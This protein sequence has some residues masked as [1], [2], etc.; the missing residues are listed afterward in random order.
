MIDYDKP[1]KIFIG[2]HNVASQIQ[3]WQRGFE[4]LGHK[5]TS[6]SYDYG[7]GRVSF[8]ADIN[9]TK[10]YTWDFGGVRPQSFRKYLTK[11][12]FGYRTRLLNK[13][14]K[15]HDIFVFIWSSFQN[16]FSDLERIKAAGKKVVVA[17]VGSDVRWYHAMVQDF[18]KYDMMPQE[19]GPEFIFNIGEL[20]ERLRRMRMV[21]RYADL[22]FSLPNQSQLAL[23]PYNHFQVIV[24]YEAIPYRPEQRER[25]LVIHAPSKSKVKGTHYIKPV[26]EKLKE[27]LGYDVQYVQGL[28]YK[29]ALA[30][31]AEAD[32]LVG[33]AFCPTGGKQEREAMSAGTVV[34]SSMQYH[35]PDGMPPN[36]PVIDIDPRNLEEKLRKAVLDYDDRKERAKLGRPFVQKYYAPEVVAKRT[37]DL[38]KNPK[39]D[40]T[41]SFFREE[42]KP[43]LEG[44]AEQ[45]NYYTSL[46]KDCD[47]YKELVPPGERDGLVF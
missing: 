46:V 7:L 27:E 4:A 26:M 32:I 40:H 36:C 45:Y 39:I 19:Y 13:V 35:Y 15:D 18:A 34:L 8:K 1:L 33:Q 20:R 37:I 38:L 21:E 31:Y 3:D 25:P 10:S 9:L 5:V 29:K 17:F 6:A 44:S 42:F 30:L 12:F 16:D 11:S 28:E 24:D 2:T 23:R 41:P 14:I 47:W 43:V 22:I